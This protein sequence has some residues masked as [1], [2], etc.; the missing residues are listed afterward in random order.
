MSRCLCV[1]MVLKFLTFL[2]FYQ[3]KKE[4]LQ[5]PTEMMYNVRRRKKSAVKKH[6][7]G[8]NS[9]KNSC[10]NT[11]KPKT[12][13]IQQ[14]S[15]KLVH[16]S[17]SSQLS[18]RRSKNTDYS[19]QM[20][21]LRLYKD[22]KTLKTHLINDQVQFW[23][24]TSSVANLL[25]DYAEKKNCIESTCVSSSLQFGVFVVWLT[26]QDAFKTLTDN[27]YRY[28]SIMPIMSL[29]AFKRLGS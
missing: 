19:Q 11:R 7:H 17:N 3:K 23:K 9:L 18:S 27:N 5:V 13:S 21:P 26:N 2:P 20:N 22:I 16:R 14:T 28:L 29:E 4:N 8:Q 12:V 24:L 1:F 15:P 6:A 10:A 25:F